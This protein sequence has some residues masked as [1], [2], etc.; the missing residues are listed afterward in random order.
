MS[1][2]L[3]HML[4]LAMRAVILVLS[5][6]IVTDAL[7]AKAKDR[8][9]CA[10]CGPREGAG[11][12]PVEATAVYKGKTYSFCSLECKVE[13]L[14][15]PVEFLNTDEG[16]PAPQF[17]LKDL[18][19]KSVSLKSLGNDVLLL[20]FW[21]TFC[22]PCMK[23]LPELQALHTKYR[24][25]GFSVVGLTVDDR[26]DLVK[27]AVAAAR[28]TY[29]TLACT[30]EVWNAYRI[31]TLPSLVLVGRDGKIIRRYGGEADKAAMLREIEKALAQ[32]R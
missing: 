20:D 13:F 18:T 22:K 25:Q 19:G 8:V 4:T 2:V 17:A 9:V 21:A 27:R 14:R 11:F 26:A 23:A 16:K 24:A 32:P 10:V 12:E 15:N 6:L 29:P 5:L 31:S 7:G 3:W 1:G 30:N 28:V